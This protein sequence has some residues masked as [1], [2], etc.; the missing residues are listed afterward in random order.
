VLRFK[1]MATAGLVAG[2]I[3]SGGLAYAAIP[4]P[5]GT[6][7]GC[8][9]KQAGLFDAKGA[10]RVVDSASE[11]RSSELVLTWSQ[12]GQPGHD[13]ADGEPGPQGPAGPAG[14]AA[15][16][17]VYFVS[18]P[19]TDFLAPE[20]APYTL[21]SM[22]LPAG[23]YVL[24]ARVNVRLHGAA[25]SVTAV[26][27]SIPGADSSQYVG[28]LDGYLE[29]AQMDLTSAITHP[30]GTVA[31]TCRSNFLGVDGAQAGYATLLATKVDSVG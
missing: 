1:S 10:V 6:I 25:D 30:G 21:V 5:D 8:Y 7:T 9:T 20:G 2:I 26:L 3:V 28:G 22:D 24:Q 29:D 19:A 31:I 18:Y 16:T 27:C 15:T 12:K 17:N 13:G 4:D 23:S 11:C 14:P